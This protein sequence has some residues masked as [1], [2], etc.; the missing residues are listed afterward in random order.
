[1]TIAESI[2]RVALEIGAIRI[3]AQQPFTWASGY[4]MPI[5]ND[6]RLLLGN[7]QNR[8]LIAKGFQ[9]LLKKYSIDVE[10]IAGTATAGIPHATTLAD[11]LQVSMV[12]VRSAAKSHGMGNKIEGILKKNQ[13]VLVIEDL[14]STGASA[15]NAVTAIRE[16]GGIV[17]HCFSI[18]SYG[19]PESLEKFK[20]VSCQIH[21]ILDLSDLLKVAQST[22]NIASNDIQTLQSW[23]ESPFKWGNKSL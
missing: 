4:K 3:N 15:I 8:N 1:M 11:L 20:S 23:Q 21:S 9:G 7:A 17:D 2:A 13:Q 18:F 5:Y 10:V 6:N 16:A 14:I 19:F 12:Y 22:Q